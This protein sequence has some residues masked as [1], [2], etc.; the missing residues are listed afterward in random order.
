ML[1]FCLSAV[2][3]V[4]KLAELRPGL[5]TADRLLVGRWGRLTVVRF[6]F[7]DCF[8]AAFED[9]GGLAFCFGFA[10]WLVAVRGRLFGCFLV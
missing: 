2:G 9:V 1:M 6:G 10:D 3:A 7:A 8:L 5:L 4:G